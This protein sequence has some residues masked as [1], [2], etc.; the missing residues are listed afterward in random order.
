MEIIF[1]LDIKNEKVV[2]GIQGKRY[3]YAP[4]KNKLFDPPIPENIV[5]TVIKKYGIN[6]FYIA[7]LNSIMKNGNNFFIL[8]SLIQK[9]KFSDFYIDA[10]IYNQDYISDYLKKGYSKVIIGLETLKNIGIL[11]DLYKQYGDKILFSLDL[12]NGIPVT[13]DRNLLN[14]QASE[15]IKLVK[16]YGAKEIIFLDIN[17]VGAMLGH[18]SVYTSLVETWGS[19]IDIFVAGGIKSIENISEFKKLGVKGVILASLIYGNLI[20]YDDI[21]GLSGSRT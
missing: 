6:K 19:E 10:G 4:P 15:I 7:D 5:N 8:D 16:N 14:K 12:Y 2:H 20:N 11:K 18:N 1:A 9:F 3:W 21:R 17:S 13:S